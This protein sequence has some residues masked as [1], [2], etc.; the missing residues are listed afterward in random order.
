[1]WQSVNIRSGTEWTD[2]YAFSDLLILNINFVNTKYIIL[3]KYHLTYLSKYL[4]GFFSNL[5][6]VRDAAGRGDLQHQLEEGRHFVHELEHV[7]QVDE[8]DVEDGSCDKDVKQ[9]RESF[10]NIRRRPH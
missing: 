2:D 6:I 1:M 9:N 3:Q 10:H 5:V 4:D 7:A 8:G